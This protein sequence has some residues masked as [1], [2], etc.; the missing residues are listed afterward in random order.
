MSKNIK[1]TG[2]DTIEGTVIN[3]KDSE[4][5]MEK[6]RKKKKEILDFELKYFFVSLTVLLSTSVYIHKTVNKLNKLKKIILTYVYA[7]TYRISII[8]ISRSFS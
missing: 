6:Y 3:I 8:I 1:R 2:K 5:P 7:L 4:E